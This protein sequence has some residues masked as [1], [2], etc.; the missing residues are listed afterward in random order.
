MNENSNSPKFDW[1]PVLAAGLVGSLL[2]AGLMWSVNE[3]GSVVTNERVA[4]EEESATID[5]V[6]KVL[7][8]VVAIVSSEN[9][10]S[11][12]GGVFEQTGG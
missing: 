2:T 3:V 11:F 5:A 10:E 7:P 1:L 4:V 9:V 8:S 12:F 6:E